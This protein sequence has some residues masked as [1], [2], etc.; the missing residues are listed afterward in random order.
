MICALSCKQNVV[1]RSQKRLTGKQSMRKQ[2]QQGNSALGE[3]PKVII[4]GE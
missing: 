3:P 1:T 2:Q 4:M